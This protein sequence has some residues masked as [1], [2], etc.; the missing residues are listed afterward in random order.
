MSVFKERTMACLGMAFLGA[1][2]LA[3]FLP[4]IGKLALLGGVLLFCSLLILLH[5]Q[6]I[7]S[8]VL[9]FASVLAAVVLSYFT[10]ELPIETY[11][12]LIDGQTH[13]VEGEV[14]EMT[15]E[16]TYMATFT[17]NVTAI[18]GEGADFRAVVETD[19][20]FAA[21]K[22]QVLLLHAVFSD[23]EVSAD[24]FPEKLYQYS[25]GFLL[26]AVCSEEP[27]F[28]SDIGTG[29]TLFERIASFGKKRLARMLSNDGYAFLSAILL[30]DRS[31]LSP[32]IKRD[33]SALGISHVLAVSG[34]HLSIV[35]GGI[36]WLLRTL[37][38]HKKLR[39]LLLCALT[40]LFM[41]AMGF[42]PSVLRSGLMYILFQLAFF[43]RRESDSLTNLFSAASLICLISP[44]SILDTGFLL[45][46]SAT[47]GILVLGLPMTSSLRE[48]LRSLPS[49]L[50]TPIRF[51][52]E[53]VCISFAASLFTVPIMSLSFGEVSV[54]SLLSNLLF[55][56]L[57]SLL[58]YCGMLL[59]LLADLPLLGIALA[60][61]S[62]ALTQLF[63]TLADRFGRPL[64]Y[65][66][67]LRYPFVLPI[68]CGCVLI[69]FLLFFF[70]RKKRPMLYLIP[71]FAGLFAYGIGL[72][73]HH[74]LFKNVSNLT[75]SNIKSN[76]TFV[77][78]SDG[79]CHLFD[80]TDGSSRHMRRS[81]AIASEQ[82]ATRITSYTVTHYHKRHISTFQTLC[83]SEY[84]SIVRL[85]RPLDEEETDIAFRIAET[86]S[87]NGV[88]VEY[89]DYGQ[90]LACGNVSV[91]L[92][93]PYFI[94]RSVQPMVTLLF[95]GGD[96][97]LLY[98]SAVVHEAGYGEEIASIDCDTLLYGQHGPLVKTAFF[99]QREKE[100]HL[101]SPS[102][103]TFANGFYSVI[104]G[105]KTFRLSE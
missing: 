16:T 51:V 56:P 7:V 11:H 31:G 68:V 58:L 73:I 59:L 80:V 101:A 35:L 40:A 99:C 105:Q 64:G 28:L 6:E 96:S 38:V 50:R 84:L 71:I 89:F 91:T 18:E 60:D 62:D 46:V 95:E 32:Q 83:E 36:E 57:L 43:A 14:I 48:K 52:C 12:P 61:A 49:L 90:P 63:L 77:L 85:P 29:E 53:T 78:L 94:K 66:V 39:C 55:L 88:S 34:L 17:L 2:A 13:E 104:D 75:A 79:G 93:E 97:S 42:S 102:L 70:D 67:S 26:K 20:P 54:M 76:E 69:F 33:F 22:G 5:R 41:G 98:T 21:E 4:L 8:F 65:C 72:S 45:S 81:L 100:V 15:F 74:T 86:A 92:F 44:H 37:T 10:F 82:Y 47:F 24:S 30:G 3:F 87:E 9:L 103:C 1:S 27:A 23:F 19:F 25:Q